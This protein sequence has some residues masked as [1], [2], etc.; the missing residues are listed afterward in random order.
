MENYHLKSISSNLPHFRPSHI[1]QQVLLKCL[2]SS[3]AHI[4]NHLVRRARGQNLNKLHLQ[5]MQTEGVHVWKIKSLN[6][7]LRSKVQ[8]EQAKIRHRL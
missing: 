7:G 4:I 6:C 1:D 3:I 5:H 8:Q 2:T